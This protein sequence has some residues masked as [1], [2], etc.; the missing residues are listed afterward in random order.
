MA[1]LEFAG[2]TYTQAED[3]AKLMKEHGC[4]YEKWASVAQLSATKM[5]WKLTHRKLTH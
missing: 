4:L 5:F 1:S 3:I 2:R